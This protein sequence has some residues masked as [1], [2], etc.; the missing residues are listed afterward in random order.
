MTIRSA[1]YLGVKGHTNDGCVHVHWLSFALASQTLLTWLCRLRYR[2]RWAHI[3]QPLSQREREKWRWILH[4]QPTRIWFRRCAVDYIRIISGSWK[5]ALIIYSASFKMVSTKISL[6]HWGL[7]TLFR[8]A[9]RRQSLWWWRML[10]WNKW[11]HS[12][13]VDLEAVALCSWVC[14]FSI[15]FISYPIFRFY[16]SFPFSHRTSVWSYE[17][18]IADSCSR[19][20]HRCTRCRQKDDSTGWYNRVH[21][22]SFNVTYGLILIYMLMKA[23]PRYGP[24]THWCHSPLC[25]FFLGE[26]LS[27]QIVVPS[28]IRTTLRHTMHPR[29]LFSR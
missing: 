25:C 3:V 2:L 13:Q 9:R 10:R 26:F 20:L 1:F 29:R 18:E 28:K 4:P 14:P 7:I 21:H 19:T 17:D 6:S 5:Q 16:I 22:P 27:S 24:P 23:V 12:S 11:K 8:V 15:T